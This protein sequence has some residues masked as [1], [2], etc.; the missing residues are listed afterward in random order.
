VRQF[1]AVPGPI[2]DLMNKS[3]GTSTGNLK[4]GKAVEKKRA[5]ASLRPKEDKK[6][7]H[8]QYTS[9]TVERPLDAAAK[10][11]L[12]SDENEDPT[13]PTIAL[14]VSTQQKTK[15]RRLSGQGLEY[16][17]DDGSYLF[18]RKPKEMG[19]PFVSLASVPMEERKLTKRREG[20]AVGQKT[21]FFTVRCDMGQRKRGGEGF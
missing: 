2:N 20:E 7:S 18:P 14:S 15:E 1:H 16:H 6:A 9:S 5:S 13:T 4:G 3:E 12:E 21:L 19:T 10:L 11:E 8:G 17:L